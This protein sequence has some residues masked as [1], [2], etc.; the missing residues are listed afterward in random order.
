MTE[1]TCSVLGCGSTK[2]M[3]RGWCSTHYKRWRRHGDPLAAVNRRAPDGSTLAERLDYV[4]WSVTPR[5]VGMTPCW[6]WD[7]LRDRRGYGRL[8]DGERVQAAHRVAYALAHGTEPGGHVLHQCDNPPCVNPDHLTVGDDAANMAEMV[9]RRRSDNGERRWSVKLTDEDV[10][11]IRSAYT[12]ERGQQARLAEQYGVS[13]SRISVIVRGI[14]RTSAT[15][16]EAVHDDGHPVGDRG[17]HVRAA[18]TSRAEVA[19]PG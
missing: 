18:E 3:A 1:R 10:A 5:R 13:Q 4:G 2:I 12:G 6:E 14:A 16:W 8:W 7:G 15:N 11:A 19:D 17:P 9:T